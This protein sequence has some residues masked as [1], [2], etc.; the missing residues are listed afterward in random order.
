VPLLEGQGTAYCASNS[1]LPAWQHLSP[2]SWQTRLRDGWFSS[3]QSAQTFMATV[4]MM[5]NGIM[6]YFLLLPLASF[7]AGA[8]GLAEA[9]AL[10]L[11]LPGCSTAVAAHSPPTDPHGTNCHTCMASGHC[12][13]LSEMS[14]DCA[15]QLLLSHTPAS[16]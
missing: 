11:C 9:V 3:T 10:G 8:L 16:G 2:S 13:P 4:S 7:L 15:C 1:K 5:T 14:C 12:V 6:P